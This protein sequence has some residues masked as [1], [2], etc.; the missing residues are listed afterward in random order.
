MISRISCFNR[1]IFRRSLRRT[2]PLWVVYLIFWVIALP[3]QLLIGFSRVRY[4]VSDLQSAIL[5]A[6]QMGSSFVCFLYGAA[7]AWLIFYWLFRSRSA[8]FYASLPVRRETVFV[9]DYCAGL[10]VGLVPNVAVFLLSLGATAM[11]G[12]PQ[13]LACLQWLGANCLSFLFF[14]SFAVVCCMVIGQIAAMPLLYLV[15]NFAVYVLD[16]IVRGLLRTFVYGMPDGTDRLAMRFSPLV[17]LLDGDVGPKAV[18]VYDNAQSVYHT[19]SYGFTG[20][21]YLLALGGAGLLFAA[22]AFFLYRGREMERSG[23]VIAVRALRPIFLYFFTVGCALVL[24]DGIMYLI[25]GQTLTANFFPVLFCLILGAF[26]GYTAAQMMLQKTMRV[27]THGWWDYLVVCLCLILF[28][29]A[30][31]L[32]LFGYSRRVPDESKV[33]SVTVSAYTSGTQD[34]PCTDADAIRDTLALHSYTV[35]H[36]LEIERA[37]RALDGSS[38]EDG[39]RQDFYLTYTLKDGGTLTRKYSAPVTPETLGDPESLISRFTALYN[40]PAAILARSTPD[41]ELRPAD[42]TYC[43]INGPTDETGVNFD[44]VNLGSSEAYDFYVNCLLPDLQNGSL[45]STSF[46]IYQ[47][48]KAETWYPVS[49]T[50]DLTDAFGRTFSYSY[51]VSAAAEKTAAYVE[52]LG[53]CTKLAQ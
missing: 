29:G 37:L 33:A 46:T 39:Y 8:Y 45:G 5:T 32:D 51:N 48:G 25:G 24:G 20:W 26:L 9:T 49:V 19:V 22:A 41:W 6:A 31:R 28:F 14:Y 42:I 7:C 3:L 2:A 11:L 13:P 47:D 1:A 44:T 21:S 10:V 30:A 50:L 53:F 15:L 36:Q 17:F 27:F 40:S 4:E 34:R 23:D 12:T 18:S 38:Y 52:K 16:Y 43:S 35:G